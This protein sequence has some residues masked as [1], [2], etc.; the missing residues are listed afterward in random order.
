M[1]VREQI[2]KEV[3]NTD[4]AQLLSELMEV[5]HQRQQQ[6]AHRGRY[7]AFMR[8][9]GLLAGDGGQEMTSLMQQELSCVEQVA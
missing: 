9:R 4:D 1:T 7:E 2:I 3:A 6:D 5:L 8:H